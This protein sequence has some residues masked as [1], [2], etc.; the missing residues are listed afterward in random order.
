MGVTHW[1]QLWRGQ[2]LLQLL[3]LLL[4]LLK[5]VSLL[6]CQ[7]EAG[8]TQMRRC[9][10]PIPHN[11]QELP[12][13]LRPRQMDSL[14]RRPPVGTWI[15]SCSLYLGSPLSR[16]T[17]RSINPIGP[18]NYFSLWGNK[19]LWGASLPYPASHPLPRAELSLTC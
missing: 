4:L 14:S 10:R 17:A 15:R 11:T 9:K 16:Q 3:Q 8:I 12:D 1:G 13:P 5:K 2:E 19:G 18:G 6:L 7:A